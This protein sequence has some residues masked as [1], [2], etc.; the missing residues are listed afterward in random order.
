[1]LEQLFH[2]NMLDMRWK[3][4]NEKIVIIYNNNE[5]RLITTLKEQRH[6]RVNT[7]GQE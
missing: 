6:D 3:I 7:E 5:A 1:M 2:E 4:T